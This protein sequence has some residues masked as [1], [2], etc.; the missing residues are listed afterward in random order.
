MELWIRSQDK[1]S[2]MKVEKL[3]SDMFPTDS[4]YRIY[5]MQNE[6]ELGKYL[7][8]ERAL[9]VLDEIQNKMKQQFIVKS[10]QILSSKDIDREEIR[11]ENKYNAEFIMQ[12]SAFEIIPIN[13]DFILYEMPKE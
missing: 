12:D 9:E 2:L 7:T 5:N 8:R 10:S 4:Y 1:S 13:G 6:E 11:L 3:Y